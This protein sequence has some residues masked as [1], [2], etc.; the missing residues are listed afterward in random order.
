VLQIHTPDSFAL[1]AE[2][3]AGLQA[4]QAFIPQVLL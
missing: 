2:L 3:L 1:R 4:P